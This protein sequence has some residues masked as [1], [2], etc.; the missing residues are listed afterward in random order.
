MNKLIPI[1][2][3][4]IL[5]LFTEFFIFNYINSSETI[6]W[7]EMISGSFSL[8]QTERSPSIP[9]EIIGPEKV[10]GCSLR[11]ACRRDEAPVLGSA[12]YL[13]NQAWVLKCFKLTKLSTHCP[14]CATQSVELQALR[15]VRPIYG[16]DTGLVW[17]TSDIMDMV[18][19]D[20]LHFMEWN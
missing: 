6:F 2:Y 4:W 16:A 14:L 20:S 18:K 8:S 5:A 15:Q 9:F 1:A 12:W 3:S 10:F 17:S 11:P 19:F 7:H 13:K